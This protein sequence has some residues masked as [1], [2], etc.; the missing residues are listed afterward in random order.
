[1]FQQ[2]IQTS[3]ILWWGLKT[4]DFFPLEKK[5]REKEFSLVLVSELKK[6]LKGTPQ[7]IVIMELFNHYKEEFLEARDA[8]K[9]KIEKIPYLEPSKDK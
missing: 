3:E 9:N 5:K 6:L 2:C 8:V 4:F 1:V 7:I